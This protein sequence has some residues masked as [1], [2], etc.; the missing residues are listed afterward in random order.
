MFRL[1]TPAG[2]PWVGDESQLQP[3]APPADSD[4]L[5]T[6]CLVYMDVDEVDLLNL[7]QNQRFVWRKTMTDTQELQWSREQVNP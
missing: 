1:S 3:E 4:A 5:D 2:S 6:F 7:K